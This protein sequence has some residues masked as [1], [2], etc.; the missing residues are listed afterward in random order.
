MRRFA[1]ARFAF[2]LIAFSFVC[3]VHTT[4]D[5]KAAAP[6]YATKEAQLKSITAAEASAYVKYLA[7]ARFEGRGCWEKGGIAAADFLAGEFKKARL[8]PLGE[9]DTYFECFTYTFGDRQDWTSRNVVGMV[10]GSDETL[11]SEFVVLGAHY[12]HLGLRRKGQ[13]WPGADDNASGTAAVCELAEA[14]G[15]GG[16]RPKR[17][18][19]FALFGAEER[20]LF[21]SKH[22]TDKP[23]VPIEKIVA[24]INLD[25]IGRNK[26][27][28]VSI[29]GAA[30][31]TDLEGHLAAAAK[32]I[33]LKLK[34]EPPDDFAGS[35]HY[36]FYEKGIPVL[37]L[38]SGLHNDYHKQ[39]DKAEK[40][41]YAKIQVTAQLTFLTA[42]NVAEADAR[43]NFQKLPKG[44][45]GGRLG[46]IPAE[47]DEATEQAL[48]LGGYTG[49]RVA[50]VIK[51][52]PADNVQMQKDDIIIEFDGKKFSEEGGM[53]EFKDLVKNAKKD[54]PIKM[55]V[56][57]NKKRGNVTVVLK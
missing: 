48:G 19:I 33:K 35:D 3:L 49:I 29:L 26:P 14:F 24:M 22:F 32:S 2:C 10:E 55:V 18:I 45:L 37:F 13:F 6:A 20:G 23:P 41:D 9:A 38:H 39:S 54:K 21:G 5:E 47:I 28:E 50:E 15:K 8:I 12:D 36:Y 44:S 34:Y 25:M 31:S 43:P 7:S 4:A 17:S 42:W 53:M 30:T 46:I 16:Q 57:R 56:V 51:G 1:A 11:K 40:I 27:G 52:T